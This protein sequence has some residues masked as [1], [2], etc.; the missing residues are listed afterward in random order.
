MEKVENPWSKGNKATILTSL[1]EAVLWMGSGGLGSCGYWVLFLRSSPWHN[2]LFGY[3]VAQ[4][5]CWDFVACA[6]CYGITRTN[7]NNIKRKIKTALHRSIQVHF[8][9]MVMM[10]SVS[11]RFI[12]NKLLNFRVSHYFRV[13]PCVVNDLEILLFLVNSKPWKLVPSNSR[14][15][16]VEINI[17][18]E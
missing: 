17:F 6:V 12:S 13:N 9:Y 4:S 1:P 11:C 8:W 3:V 5:A 2:W 10:V 7:A 16:M 14:P 18:F 15:R